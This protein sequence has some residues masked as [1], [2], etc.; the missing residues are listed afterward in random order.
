VWESDRG[1]D[2]KV[3]QI[4]QIKKAVHMRTL[5]EKGEEISRKTVKKRVNGKKNC[6]RLKSKSVGF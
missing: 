5:G 3:K 6:Q 2:K 4:T 1:N